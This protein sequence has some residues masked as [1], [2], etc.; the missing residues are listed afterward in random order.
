MRKRR[1][2]SFQLTFRRRSNDGVGL[3]LL[4]PAMVI[5]VKRHRIT[6]KKKKETKRVL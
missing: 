6:K 3:G 4:S 2:L 1:C 5:H